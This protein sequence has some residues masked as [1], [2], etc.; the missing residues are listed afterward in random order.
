MVLPE[1]AGEAAS[2]SLALSRFRSGLRRTVFPVLARGL[3]RRDK[4]FHLGL[5]IIRFFHRRKDYWQSVIL[6][7]S[8]VYWSISCWS[9]FDQG[10]SGS[11]WIRV[12]SKD[13]GHGEG[14]SIEDI[15]VRVKSAIGTVVLQWVDAELDL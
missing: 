11:I 7:V 15:T 6:L 2:A 5:A 9:L 12:V 8:H 1:R 10:R 4:T 14:R 13:V 3:L